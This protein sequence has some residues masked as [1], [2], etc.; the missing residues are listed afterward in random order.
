MQKRGLCP[1]GLLLVLGLLWTPTHAWAAGKDCPFVGA[2]E[3][4][5]ASRDLYW[6][7]YTSQD[8]QVVEGNSNK[9]VSK[10]GKL[11]YQQYNLK[12]GQS[13]LSGLEIMSNYEQALADAGATITN[14]KRAGD[15]DIYA[16]LTKDGAEYWFYIWESNGDVVG[17]KV[18]QVAPF[19]GTMIAPSGNDYP[20][21]GHLPQA[22]ARAPIKTNYDEVAFRVQADKS[23]QDVKVRGYHYKV[24]YDLS[25]YRQGP[26]TSYLEAQQNYRAALKDLGADILFAAGSDDPHTVARLDDKGKTVWIDIDSNGA[27]GVIASITVDVIEEKPLQMTIKPPQADEMKTALDHDG[28]ITLYV[29]FDFNKATLKPDAQPV[30]AQVVALLKANPD[31]KLSIEGHTDNIGLHDYNLKLSKDRAAAVVA[32]LVAQSIDAGRLSST[33]YGSDKPIAPN[34]TDAGRAKNRRVE[35]VKG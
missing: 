33:G 34:E 20:L 31:L 15:D 11:C 6:W 23:T 27:A 4:F 9:T 35:L 24:I 28:K 3:N 8:F 1:I 32:A 14:S 13:K 22:I 10:A 17:V 19:K 7:P 21:L 30:I 5:P 29:N 12:S 16:T 26:Y 18:L 2:L 25:N